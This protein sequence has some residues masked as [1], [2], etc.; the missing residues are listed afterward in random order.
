MSTCEGGR[1]G[2][3]QPSTS[4]LEPPCTQGP[5]RSLRPSL[6]RISVEIIEHQIWRCAVVLIVFHDK[7][8]PGEEKKQ[9][10]RGR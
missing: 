6:R 3:I 7:V 10:K 9:N 1:A 2:T 5:K 8:I 4:F